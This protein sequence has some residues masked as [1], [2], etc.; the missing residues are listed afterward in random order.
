M[1][2]MSTFS[3]LGFSGKT[4]RATPAGT[5]IV[6]HLGDGVMG[7]DVIFPWWI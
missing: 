7:V 5:V 4:L 2:K 1:F 6:F 3:R